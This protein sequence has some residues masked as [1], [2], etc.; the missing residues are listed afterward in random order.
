[1]STNIHIVCSSERAAGKTLLARICG[2]ILSF[3]EHGVTVFDTAFPSGP[4]ARWFPKNGEVIDFRKMREQVRLFDTMVQ[5]PGRRNYVVELQ[6]E[7]LQRFFTIL[8]DTSFDEGARDVGIGTGVFFV[9]GPSEDT[10]EQISWIRSKL[11]TASLTIVAEGGRASASRV[12]ARSP[13]AI[14]NGNCRETTL[15]Q[16]SAAT[17]E[18]VEKPGFQFGWNYSGSVVR[19]PS[20]VKLEL[21]FFM[22]KLRDWSRSPEWNETLAL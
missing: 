11:K 6:Q 19:P 8:H 4:L 18:W 22:E 17:E 1:M 15:P 12:S 3:S 5:Q 2:D 7:Y 14:I 16:L 21:S 13:R 9:H 20:E 10:R